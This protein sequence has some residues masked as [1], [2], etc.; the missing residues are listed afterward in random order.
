MSPALLKSIVHVKKKNFIEIKN[1]HQIT[2]NIKQSKR[3]LRPMK[4]QIYMYDR[5]K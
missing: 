4:A 5:G 2:M 3:V 1:L